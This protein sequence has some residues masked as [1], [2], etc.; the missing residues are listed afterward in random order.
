MANKI[1]TL[2]QVFTPAELVDEMLD[3]LPSEVWSNKDLTW[4]DPS[5]G[6]GNFLVAIKKRLMVGLKD[7]IHDE[8]ERKQYIL[9]NMLYGVDIDPDVV[10]ECI[11]RLKNEDEYHL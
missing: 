4:C 1:K 9:E 6:N 10:K 8:K 5:C 7:V 11:D 3:K 2:G